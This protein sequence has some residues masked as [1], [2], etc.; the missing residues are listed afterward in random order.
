MT[1]VAQRDAGAR[2]AG[3]L[4][5]LSVLSLISGLFGLQVAFANSAARFWP[6]VTGV[7]VLALGAIGLWIAPRVREGVRAAR[8]SAIGISSLWIASSVASWW[9][10][11]PPLRHPHHRDD[12]P[13]LFGAAALYLLVLLI[14]LR[15]PPEERRARPIA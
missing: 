8:L 4:R 9:F 7:A 2:P 1:V 13:L 14:R 10:K 5:V 3:W 11:A 12:S 6:F 15:V